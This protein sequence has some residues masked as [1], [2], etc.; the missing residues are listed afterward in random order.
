[1]RA[2]FNNVNIVPFLF[3]IR[4]YNDFGIANEHRTHCVL[5]LKE[6]K[7][8]L[9]LENVIIYGIFYRPFTERVSN[10]IFR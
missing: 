4:K 9:F 1:M 3:I 2:D 6:A 10:C 7:V 8:Y 5:L